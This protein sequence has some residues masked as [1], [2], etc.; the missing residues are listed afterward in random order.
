[1]N[2]EKIIAITATLLFAFLGFLLI[3]NNNYLYEDNISKLS[4]KI[5]DSNS[6]AIENSISKITSSAIILGKYIEISKGETDNFKE[7]SKTLYK[8]FEGVT[9]LQLAKDGIV[10]HIYPQKGHEKAL[11]HDIFKD[12]KRKKEAFLAKNSKKLT[13]AGPFKLIQGGVAIIV[14]KPIYI[15]NKFWG[16]ASSLIM[17]EDLMNTLELDK[18]YNEG[19]IFRLTRIHPDTKETDIFYGEKQFQDDKKTFT[20]TINV[21]NGRWYLDIQYVNSYI[22]ENL[23]LLYSI[24]NILIS[25]LFGSFLYIVMKKPKEYI[26]V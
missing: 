10:S 16:F 4:S 20:K 5:I 2:K 15:E 24:L 18:L 26:E 19:Y 23:V 25:I 6:T 1:M 7:F 13:L 11:G 9:N 12:D 8:Q 21:P 3:K 17:I 14:R 22:S